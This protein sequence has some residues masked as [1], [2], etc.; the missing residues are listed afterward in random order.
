MIYYLISGLLIALSGCA[1][2]FK[3]AIIFHYWMVDKKLHLNDLFWDYTISYVNKYKGKDYK[4]GQTFRGRWFTFTTDGFHLTKWFQNIFLFSSIP[5]LLH[6]NTSSF[7][8]WGYVLVACGCWICRG[9]GF[10]IIFSIF[11]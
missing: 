6:I 8:W 5:F 1:D 9:I 2:G 11:K 4:N 7:S 10:T 3:D